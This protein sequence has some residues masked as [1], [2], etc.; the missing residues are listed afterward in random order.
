MSN[1]KSRMTRLKQ[2]NSR[3]N[4][5]VVVIVQEGET[6]EQSRARVNPHPR[7]GQLVVIIDR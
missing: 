5:P 4:K 1:L 2:Q 6:V 3:R 7:P